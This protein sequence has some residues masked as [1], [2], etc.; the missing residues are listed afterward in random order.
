[1]IFLDSGAV[2]IPTVIAFLITGI[3]TI[4]ITVIIPRIVSRF[5]FIIDGTYS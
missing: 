5:D 2:P 1:M 4:N 3:L